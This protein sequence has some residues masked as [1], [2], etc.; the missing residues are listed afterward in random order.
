MFSVS[1]QGI[2]PQDFKK[3]VQIL[4]KLC[5]CQ[6]YAEEEEN[7]DK[8]DF[9]KMVF[10]FEKRKSA[11]IFQ[12]VLL[13]H[14]KKVKPVLTKVKVDLW[15]KYLKPF[16]IGALK[17]VPFQDGFKK[18]KNEI[19]L[20]IGEAFGTGHHETTKLC[21][22]LLQKIPSQKNILDLG[23]GSG[24]LTLAYLEKYPKSFLESVDIDPKAL[25]LTQENLFLNKKEAQVGRKPKRKKYDLVLA[26]ILLETLIEL[27]DFLKNQQYLILS[28]ITQDQEKILLQQFSSMKCLAIRRK[29]N[30]SA[31][32]LGHERTL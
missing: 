29:N 16:K 9:D 19:L 30:W 3:N 15:K 7:P 13:K 31:L 11:E 10:F 28:G 26:N 22:D 4:S 27:K 17:I 6:G 12:E 23:C 32:L 2:F 8:E 24:I 20:K 18:K 14:N 21:L 25:K 5:Q 1:Y